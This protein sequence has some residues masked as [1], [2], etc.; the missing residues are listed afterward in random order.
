MV[1]ELYINETLFISLLNE[2]LK[3]VLKD[4]YKIEG[5]VTLNSE[6]YKFIRQH[7]NIMESLR[8]GCIIEAYKDNA[9][10]RTILGTIKEDN[11]FTKEKYL[12]VIGKQEGYTLEQA[13]ENLE[14]ST[15]TPKKS[16]TKLYKDKRR[17]IIE[18]V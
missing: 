1:K 10:V 11:E 3:V 6:N 12:E 7:P 8:D 14:Y 16:K 13:L 2:K 9:L 17:Y 18:K 15:H 4:D 5:S